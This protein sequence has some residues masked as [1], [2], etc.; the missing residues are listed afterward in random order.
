MAQIRQIKK[1]YNT[2]AQLITHEYSEYIGLCDD[3]KMY[4][5]HPRNAIYDYVN[6]MSTY[7]SALYIDNVLCI[8]L[9][10]KKIG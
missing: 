6:P 8:M 1:K 4:Y 10:A 3:N 2:I 9:K 5:V 7:V